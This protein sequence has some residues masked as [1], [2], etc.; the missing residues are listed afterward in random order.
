MLRPVFVPTSGKPR[1]GY[2]I[3]TVA[4]S[5]PPLVETTVTVAG[6]LETC[7]FLSC[8]YPFFELYL[9]APQPTTL[10]VAFGSSV[11]ARTLSC[12]LDARH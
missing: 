6:G 3:V 12:C 9:I 1:Y 2:L 11:V 10:S 4:V 8:Q 7:F 5:D